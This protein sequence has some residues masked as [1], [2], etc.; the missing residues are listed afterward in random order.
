MYYG[1][2][3]K[4]DNYESKGVTKDYLFMYLAN[5]AP[6]GYKSHYAWTSH[7]SKV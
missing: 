5:A 6:S 4:L 2:M 1:F 7:A 3:Q